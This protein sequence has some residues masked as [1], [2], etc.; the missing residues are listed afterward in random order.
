MFVDT[1]VPV[2]AGTIA[3][4]VVFP[5]GWVTDRPAAIFPIANRTFCST[6]RVTKPTE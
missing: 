6:K 4:D 3:I 5:M 1:E 2:F